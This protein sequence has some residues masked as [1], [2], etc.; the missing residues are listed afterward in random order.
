MR[1]NIRTRAGRWAAVVALGLFMAGAPVL[2]AT[3]G[4]CQGTAMTTFI[5]QTGHDITD[6][7]VQARTEVDFGYTVPTR[8]GPA[9]GTPSGAGLV[10]PHELGWTITLLG[11]SSSSATLRL[12]VRDVLL[13]KRTGARGD[14]LLDLIY[15]GV[16][17]KNWTPD[18]GRLVKGLGKVAIGAGTD[19]PSTIAKGILDVVS[20]SASFSV[21]SGVY[22]KATAQAGNPA[23]PFSRYEKDESERTFVNLG[24]VLALTILP[25]P[26]H[27][28]HAG[29]FVALMPYERY[30]S[31][32]LLY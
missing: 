26:S 24:D 4:L 8:L 10:L 30:K 5:N 32:D 15:G 2:A 18:K 27:C 7:S 20:A 12:K 6:F 23:V 14:V 29:W 25:V 11:G 16:Q 3:T 1:E 19:K 17:E 13:D 9:G 21:N 22:L 31:L 28:P